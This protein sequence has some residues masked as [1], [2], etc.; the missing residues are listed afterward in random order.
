MVEN[1]DME[2]DS[3]PDTNTKTSRRTRLSEKEMV[4]NGDTE[5]GSVPDNKTRTSRR[6][7]LSKKQMVEN[8]DT[9]HDSV[10]DTNTGTSR[11]TRLS[12][13][14]TV[15]NGAMERDSVSD[16]NT[17]TSRRTRLSKKEI[18]E[19]D[20]AG[21]AKFASE[22]KPR[23]NGGLLPKN[24]G[25]PAGEWK[26]NEAGSIPCPPENFGGFGKGILELKRLRSKSKYS[27]SELL[28]KAEDIVK[29]CEL[30]HMPAIPEGS[31]LCINLV[32]ENDMQKSKLRK[33]SSRDDSDDNYLYCPAAKDLQQEDLKHFQCHW[34]KGEPVIVGNV[35]ETASGLSWEPMV[36]WQACRQLKNLNHPLLLDVSA[37][38]CLDW[39]E[40]EVNIHHFFKGYMEGQFDSAGW[41]Q[42]LKLQGWPNF[43]E[44]RSPHLCAE[45]IRSLPF[46]EY[47]DP[48]SG[49]LNLA[50]KLPPGSLRPDIGAKTYIAYGIPQELGRGDSVT[51]LHCDMSDAVYLVAFSFGHIFL[52]SGLWIMPSEDFSGAR[53]HTHV[54]VLTHTQGIKLT[55]VQLSRIEI[56]KRTYAAQDK[57]ELQMAD[58]EQKC[59][60]GASS[61]FNEGQSL[62][63]RDTAAE[64]ITNGA[65]HFT[66]ASEASGG[67]KNDCNIDA[68]K[69]NPVFGKSE[70][71][72]DIGGA[73]WGIFRR[74]DVPK[75]EEYLRKHF[76]EFRHINCCPVPQV[77][78]P[79]HDQ[80]FYL[81]EDHKRKLK[82]KYGFEPWT[83]V[84][85]LGDAVF[86]PAGCPYQVRNLKSC[87]NVVLGFVSPEN[88][89]ECIRLTQEVRLLSQDLVAAED[90]LEVKK[91]ILYA[92]WEAIEDLAMLSQ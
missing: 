82:E 56:L 10:P 12:K 92:T 8:G 49:F 71:S 84:Q 43:F 75:L 65:I 23:D 15:E 64:G 1:G 32:A 7:R 40:A 19:N 17:R 37:T 48:Q 72:E 6:T 28:T 58:E 63:E 3:V 50:V 33:A 70:I 11:R 57:R 18:V 81:T 31:C 66:G 36:M 51:K 86:I 61:E 60:N 85:K 42:L 14:E 21:D 76:N 91:M 73:M 46:K 39:S 47:T 52:L 68:C 54:N 69:G 30:E 20:S 13:K 77:I 87:I 2:H 4:E 9:K 22:M 45:F 35:L 41:P 26:S 78:H 59:K 5:H 38:K 16:T 55:P 34:L 53:G 79:I 83:F 27:V 67:I 29:R 80:T 90:K 89:G 44:E 24:S 74:Q 88:V 25:G 62:L